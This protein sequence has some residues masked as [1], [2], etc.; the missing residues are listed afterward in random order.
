MFHQ[1]QGSSLTVI[2][3][4]LPVFPLLPQ[5]LLERRSQAQR[6][7]S[8]SCQRPS[9]RLRPR[10]PLSAPRAVLRLVPLA[11]LAQAS[12]APDLLAMAPTVRRLPKSPPSSVVLPMLGMMQACCSALPS[13]SS[14]PW[15]SSRLTAAQRRSKTVSHHSTAVLLVH[16]LIALFLS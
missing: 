5:A 11:L 14:A 4:V 10:R 6:P 2:H 1:R 7:T 3:R 9:P 13:P 8:A 15:C 16:R 12:M